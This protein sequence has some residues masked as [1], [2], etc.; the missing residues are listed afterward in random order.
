LLLQKRALTKDVQP[1]RWDTSVGG[2]YVRVRFGV[3][4]G[5]G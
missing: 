2:H 3:G 4:Q 1:G 5:A